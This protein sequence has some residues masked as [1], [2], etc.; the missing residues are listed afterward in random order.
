MKNK[1]RVSREKEFIQ[2]KTI[3]DISY[4]TLYMAAE[5]NPL[6][7]LVRKIKIKDI[8]Y[9]KLTQ[10]ISISRQTFSKHIKNLIEKGLIEIE[11]E[12]YILPVPQ[13]FYFDIDEDTLRI[14]TNFAKSN[15]IKLYVHLLG[16][17]TLKKSMNQ[18]YNYSL[19]GLCEEL[20]I[21]PRQTRNR[22]VIKDIIYALTALGLIKT[23]AEPDFRIESNGNVFWHYRLLF[24][25]DTMPKPS[26]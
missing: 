15:S 21:A 17:Y 9:S 12:Y 5:Y 19:D 24:A 20:G 3:S 25:T 7:P 13:E 6:D 10:G 1:I 14:L 23:T 4:I 16:W 2:D 8:N 26:L 11:D 18:E 22:Q